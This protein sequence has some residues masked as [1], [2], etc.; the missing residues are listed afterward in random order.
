MKCTFGRLNEK[1]DGPFIE[2]FSCLEVRQLH[3][4][5]KSNFRKINATESVIKSYGKDRAYDSFCKGIDDF[6]NNCKCNAEG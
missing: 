6:L 2:R 1:H 4:E 3:E 5:W